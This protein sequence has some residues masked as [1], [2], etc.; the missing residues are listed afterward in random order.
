[1]RSL[2]ERREVEK[3]I[4]EGERQRLTA[5]AALHD[6]SILC[7]FERLITNLKTKCNKF[8]NKACGGE[9]SLAEWIFRGMIGEKLHKG[10]VLYV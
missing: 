7:G 5:S 10:V 9:I 3:S 8:V 1:M 2:L 6:N 4:Y